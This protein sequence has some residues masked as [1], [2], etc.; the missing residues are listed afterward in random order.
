MTVLSALARHVCLFGSV[1]QHNF[2]ASRKND[3]A[4]VE[5]GRRDAAAIGVTPRR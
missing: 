3:N 5:S 2:C 1:E 4:A